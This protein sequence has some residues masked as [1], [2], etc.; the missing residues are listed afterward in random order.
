MM[1]SLKMTDLSFSLSDVDIHSLS[2]STF[3]LGQPIHQAVERTAVYW[4]WGS[5]NVAIA[6][7]VASGLASGLMA[8]WVF[9]LGRRTERKKVLA[10]ETARRSEMAFSALYKIRDWWECGVRVCQAVT[11]QIEERKN[12]VDEGAPIPSIVQPI[13]DSLPEP[14]KLSITEISFLA[15]QDNAALIDAIFAVQI[16]GHHVLALSRQ[17]LVM[18]LE[19]DS[20][21]AVN[22]SEHAST[23]DRESI[24]SEF[25]GHAGFEARGRMLKMESLLKGILADHE[26]III[27][28]MDTIKAYLAACKATY[29]DTWPAVE[30]I[31]TQ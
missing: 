29:P 12:D 26:E 9:M 15:S 14:E 17:Y 2:H 5:G 18:R 31:E 21:A 6:G 1:L 19:W 30:L 10:Q 3:L 22:A 7:G 24:Y 25:E 4:D 16:W 13:P 11:S 20:W 28:H 8:Y 23:D 27:K